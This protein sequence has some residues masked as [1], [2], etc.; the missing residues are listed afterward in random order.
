MAITDDQ[1]DELGQEGQVDIS[2]ELRLTFSDSPDEFSNLGDLPECYGRFEFLD[3]GH[4]QDQRP[5]GYDGRALKLWTASNPYWW[6]PPDGVTGENL[7]ALR[8]TVLDI[9]SF[10]FVV[11]AVRA[12]KRC[13]HCGERASEVESLGGLEPCLTGEDRR[14][15][16]RDLVETL[17]EVE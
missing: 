1:L 6:Q 10:G 4:H 9:L 3:R 12:W 7:A 17:L 16:L 13:A 11:Y 5:E 15:I 2:P 14:E 8:S